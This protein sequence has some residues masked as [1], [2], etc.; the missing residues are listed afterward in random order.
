[1]RTI[2]QK[3]TRPDVAHGSIKYPLRE[4][5]RKRGSFRVLI[6]ASITRRSRKNKHAKRLARSLGSERSLGCRGAVSRRC[7]LCKN[8][9]ES[10]RCLLVFYETRKLVKCVIMLDERGGVGFSRYPSS[11]FALS[12]GVPLFFLFFLFTSSRE[13]RIPTLSFSHAR[14]RT[15]TTV[16]LVDHTRRAKLSLLTLARDTKPRIV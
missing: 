1:M 11:S 9:R 6:I 5:E 8:A 15:R 13:I 2:V 14:Q 12:F 4:G 16:I 3:I 7:R 10:V